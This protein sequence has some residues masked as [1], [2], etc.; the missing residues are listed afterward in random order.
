MIKRFCN[1]NRFF[2]YII[3]AGSEEVK[4]YADEI[5]CMNIEFGGKFESKETE[6]ILKKGDIIYNVYGNDFY[7]EQT[8]LSNKLY[9][10]VSMCCPI[11]VSPGTYMSIITEKLGIG[12]TIDFDSPDDI[13]TILY[14]WY[15]SF[16]QSDVID[17]C[18]KFKE[19]AL[20][21]QKLIHSKL[22]V[23]LNKND[24]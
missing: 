8:A 12:F 19:D 6:T 11:L 3:G 15:Q 21:S 9:Y 18:G 2:M 10:A 1:D 5:G 24:V 13:C 4:P 7:C 14:E 17:K 22:D 23:Y 20:Q 16:A